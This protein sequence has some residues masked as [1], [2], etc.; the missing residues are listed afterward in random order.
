MFH[1]NPT[2]DG[3]YV[4]PAF[5][6][7]TGLKTLH[8]D[9][10][11]K[12]SL[13]ANAYA[14]P[15]YYSGP[16]GEMFIVATEDN[17]LIAVDGTGKTIWNHQFGSPATSGL[18]CGN[19]AASGNPLGITG[20]PVIDDQANPPVIYFDTMTAGPKHLIHAVSLADG[21][22]EQNGFPI[23][24]SARVPGFGSANQNQRGALLL[25]GGTLYVPYGGHWGDC[26]PYNGYVIGVPVSNPGGTLLEWHTTASAGGIWAVGGPATDGTSIF[27]TTGNTSGTSPSQWGSGEG[28]LRLGARLQFTGQTADYFAPRGW[29]TDDLGDVDLGSTG[30][31]LFQIGSARYA[32]AMGKDQYMYVLN[33]DSLGG[34]GGELVGTQVGTG[35]LNGSGAV[36]T[37]AKGTYVAFHV[38]N[39]PAAGCPS[40]GPSGGNLAAAKI[41]PGSPPQVSIAWCVAEGGLGSPIVSTTDGTSNVVV[42]DASDHLYGY[43]GDTGAKLF[44]GGG[45][46]SAMASSMHYF[47]S[48]I[49]AKGRIVVA[50]WNG[51]NGTGPSNLYLFRP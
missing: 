23:D 16:S 31:L 17:H 19:I 39:A 34:V 6:A 7:S 4:D 1:K 51:N 8:L 37:T 25:V 44:A 41:T 42:W 11:F 49:V 18:P 35:D 38:S 30:P 48:P 5:T 47:N 14:Q 45:S 43:D 22:T 50:T 26:G 20:T 21:K 12:V 29:F 10:T 2:R 28:L 15:L 32:V 27:V 24:V 36:Y 33:R 40:S 3:V 46:G 13:G 9:S